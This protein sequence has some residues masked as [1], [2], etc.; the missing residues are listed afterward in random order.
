RALERQVAPPRAEAVRSTLTAEQIQRVTAELTYEA[1]QIVQAAGVAVYLQAPGEQAYR[2][3]FSWESDHPIP[4][5]T[6]SLPRAF[7][8]IAERGRSVYTPDLTSVAN[9]AG[10]ADALRGLVGV[11]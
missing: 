1:R 3:T 7:H 5:S 10:T 4:S 9:A 6:T 2:A 11:P 8:E